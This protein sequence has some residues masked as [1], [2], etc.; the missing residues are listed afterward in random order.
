MAHGEYWIAKEIYRREL[1]RLEISTPEE[2][3]DE[4]YRI[5]TEWIKEIYRRELA[6]LISI[7]AEQDKNEAYHII[8]SWLQTRIDEL[9]KLCKG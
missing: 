6:R 7:T 1:I 8:I 9:E 4:K 3:R 2:Q 5:V